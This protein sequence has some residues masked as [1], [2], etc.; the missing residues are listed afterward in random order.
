MRST[1]CVILMMGF[2][3]GFSQSGGRSVYPFLG[4]DPTAHIAGMGGR[5][6]SLKDVDI[7]TAVYNPSVLSKR[8]HHHVSFN[9]NHYFE[10]IQYGFVAYGREIERKGRSYMLSSQVLY[11][12]YG[13]FDG[14]DEVGASTGTF[15]ASDMML[16]ISGSTQVNDRWRAGV[17]MKWIYSV[18][19]SYVSNGVAFD[20]GMLYSDDS[21]RLSMGF[22]LKDMG[23][24][25]IAYR[26]TSRSPLPFDAQFSITKKPE[27]APFRGTLMIHNLNR[28]DLSN[29]YIDPLD[30]RFDE[31]NRLVEPNQNFLYKALQHLT[32]GVEL[33]LSEQFQI[34]TSYHHL[35]RQELGTSVRR[36]VSGFS[37]G[38]GFKI[39]KIR[40]EYGSAA[41]FPGYN[42]NLFS[43]ILN[44]NE[45]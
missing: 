40:F 42:S 13:S 5:V 7:G 33:L 41:Y 20:V 37:W 19:E 11:L 12:D 32:L 4:L 9:Y 8:H 36:G 35:R 44:L 6:I 26:G 39:K 34:R 2:H 21:N 17:T 22:L 30:R 29:P 38:V 25:N 27:H 18:L 31:F 45:L 16:G 14:F 3:I 43:V 10:D 24:Q 15:S 23:W 28:W 1:L